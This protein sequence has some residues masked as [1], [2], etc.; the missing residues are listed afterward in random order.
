MSDVE[1]VEAAV[2][3]NDLL[4]LEKRSEF[5]EPSRRD[6]VAIDARV[7]TDDREAP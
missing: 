3:E 7:E 4:A 2:G 6:V 5:L 1:N